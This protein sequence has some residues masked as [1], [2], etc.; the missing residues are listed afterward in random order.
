MKRVHQAFAGLAALWL[1]T[2]ASGVD[3]SD[4][5]WPA[6][7]SELGR[8]ANAF[9][10][11]ET[12][13][14]AN[15]ALRVAAVRE[16]D[17]YATSLIEPILLKALQDPS[18]QVKRDALIRCGEREMLS[19][20]E[21][22]AELWGNPRATT[23]LRMYAL[24]VLLIDPKT[25]HVDLL[26]T[27]MQAP[28]PQLRTMA[29]SLAAEISLAK[30]D[31]DR[32]RAQVVAKLAD[33][34]PNVRQNALRTLGTLGPGPGALTVVTQLED[35]TPQVRREAGRTLG[36]MRD[37]RAAPALMR[38]L[39]AGDESYVS[40]AMLHALVLLPGE[41]IDRALL[42]FLDDPPRGLSRRSLS[43]KIGL[44]ANPSTELLTE[45]TARLQEQ[46]LRSYV[47]SSLM[48]QGEQA[49]EVLEA[50][51][52]RGLD[53]ASDLEVTRILA[54]LDHARPDTPAKG[55]WQ[56]APEIGPPPLTDRQT[57]LRNLQA[58]R[59]AR[60]RSALELAQARPTWVFEALLDGLF[61]LPEPAPARGYLT[62]LA[63]FTGELP[64]PS[65]LAYTVFYK[66]AQWAGN[67]ALPSSDRCLSLFALAAGRGG[68]RSLRRLVSQ[69]LE[70]LAGDAKPG[71][72]GCVAQVL[73]GTDDPL[74]AALLRDPDAGVRAQAAFALRL[75][76]RP[77][78]RDPLAAP[79]AAVAQTDPNWR[80][81]QTATQALEQRRTPTKGQHFAIDWAHVKKAT[82]RSTW[83][84]V[85][86]EV[87]TKNWSYLLPPIVLDQ[88]LG[89]LLRHA[90]GETLTVAPPEKPVELARDR[91]LFLSFER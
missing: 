7:P 38:A 45:L 25:S 2:A 19:C 50:A 84:E 6:W 57:W 44:R 53:P 41:D 36:L 69:T 70:K 49:R 65:K 26:V 34:V 72:R 58:P 33:A 48:L 18:N 83:L 74:L 15:D 89:V 3:A 88:Q 1:L 82:H 86:V 46:D 35:P 22:A 21:R 20:S 40:E 55:S 78:R 90:N 47:L 60:L 52:K 63:S 9:E 64:R 37:P 16:T 61:R 79:L 54:S 75:R 24:R 71:V 4:K 12:G 29:V 85:Q 14:L 13:N 17:A 11:D 5:R 32:V 31:L 77:K 67:V 91:G 62:A 39:R 43:K 59:R 30:K 76:A 42:A 68:P 81:R 8:L 27:A 73:S 87:N 28:D 56:T 80:V 66:M 23:S 51:Q 10:P